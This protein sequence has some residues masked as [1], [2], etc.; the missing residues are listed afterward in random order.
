MTDATGIDNLFGPL[1]AEDRLADGNAAV[2]RDLFRAIKRAVHHADL[3]T[4]RV[5]E[6][7][8]INKEE[9]RDILDGRRDLTLT[10]LEILL[11]AAKGQ[12]KATVEPMPRPISPLRVRDEVWRSAPD[13]PRAKE[14]SPSWVKSRA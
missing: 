9:A 14:A 6:R 1:T 3:D 2:V 7:M 4:E 13:G 5:A 10:E 11:I 12:L 8:G